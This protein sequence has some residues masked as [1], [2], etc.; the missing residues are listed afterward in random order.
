MY[1]CACVFLYFFMIIDVYSRQIEN[2]FNNL[3]PASRP[4]IN[5]HEV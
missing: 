1:V 4:D 5:T 2:I 3:F